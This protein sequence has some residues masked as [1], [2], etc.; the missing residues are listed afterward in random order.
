MAITPR[1]AKG[2]RRTDLHPAVL[3]FFDGASADEAISRGGANPWMY[4]SLTTE[5]AKQAREAWQRGDELGALAQLARCP[6]RPG[7]FLQ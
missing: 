4:F 3:A 5:S 6:G 1:T 2:P 7:W